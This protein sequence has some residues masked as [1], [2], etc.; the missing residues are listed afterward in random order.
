MH[1]DPR[2]VGR[3]APLYTGGLGPHVPCGTAPGEHRQ[4]FGPKRFECEFELR[5]AKANADAE[6]PRA[7]VA[8]DGSELCQSPRL[9]GA[10]SSPDA[11]LSSSGLTAFDRAH[12]CPPSCAAHPTPDAASS[13]P[14]WALADRSCAAM[15][16]A[17]CAARPESRPAS[18]PGFDQPIPPAPPGS[19]NAISAPTSKSAAHERAHRWGAD[20]ASDIPCEPGGERA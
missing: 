7:R 3:S 15:R 8:R 19:A 2:H 9:A 18:Q 6:G 16:W 4:D 14:A 12:P 11:R 1:Q 17:S 10:C 13:G 20:S 5:C